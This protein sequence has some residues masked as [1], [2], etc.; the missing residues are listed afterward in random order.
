MDLTS[1][2]ILTLIGIAIGFL[3]GILVSSL[4]GGGSAERQSAEKP[5]SSRFKEIVR[6]SRDRANDSLVV[7]VN[8]E[9]YRTVDDLAEEYQKE[10][11]LA[12]SDLRTW[13][14]IFPK[15]AQ[16]TGE[17]A[18]PSSFTSQPSSF[19]SYT[20]P[21]T[22]EETERPSLNP[23]QVFSSPATQASSQEAPTKSIVAQIDEIL[24]AKLEDT[25]L[26]SRGIRLTELP[27]E[28]MI[29]LVGFE[30]FKGVEEVP[31]EE[32]REVIHA[33]VDEWE[34]RETG[35]GES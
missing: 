35:F 4:R 17:E 32:I 10:L 15:P 23:F 24:Q 30:K 2:I 11:V 1:I 34:H 26:A 12:S 6:L 14:R 25:P 9:T 7:E 8:G 33:A 27:G 5:R 20:P 16:V 3:L 19:P 28:G 31:D 29:V 21:G 13:L 22:T 18:L